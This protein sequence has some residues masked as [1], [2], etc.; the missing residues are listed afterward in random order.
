MIIFLKSGKY[1]L[2]KMESKENVSK[3]ERKKL[4]KLMKKLKKTLHEY[5]SHHFEKM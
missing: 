1:S 4:T 3:K 2:K 5:D